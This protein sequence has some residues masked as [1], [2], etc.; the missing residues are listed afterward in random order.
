VAINTSLDGRS[1]AICPACGYPMLGKGLCALC[2][3]IA[4]DKTDVVVDAPD[5][6]PA[7]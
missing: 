5:V 3:S 6:N 2:V 7:A 1:L 4:A